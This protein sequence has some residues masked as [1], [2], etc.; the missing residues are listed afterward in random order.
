MTRT[1]NDVYI[2]IYIYYASTG[3]FD[4][5]FRGQRVTEVVELESRN[6]FFTG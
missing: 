2:Y 3:Y 4:V 1:R 6:L 5:F